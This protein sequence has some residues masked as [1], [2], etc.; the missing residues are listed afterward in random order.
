MTLEEAKEILK[1]GDAST[2][3][4][5][6]QFLIALQVVSGNALKKPEGE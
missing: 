5:R 4:K 6:E 1:N 3:E 2:A